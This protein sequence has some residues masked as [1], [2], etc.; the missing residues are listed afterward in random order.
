[1][2]GKYQN[3][4]TSIWYQKET[5]CLLSTE[6]SCYKIHTLKMKNSAYPPFYRHPQYVLPPPPIFTGKS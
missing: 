3:N 5:D 6:A 2:L 4:V 1:M